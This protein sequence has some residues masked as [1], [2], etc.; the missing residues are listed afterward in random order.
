MIP[1]AFRF[2]SEARYPSG[3]VF[4]SDG[5]ELVEARIQV[6]PT[7]GF[8]AEF[9]NVFNQYRLPYVKSDKVVEAWHQSP[10]AFWQNQVNF[11]VWCASTGCGVSKEHLKNETMLSVYRF[12]LYFQTRRILTEMKCALPQDDSWNAFENSYDRRAYEQI[13]AEFSVSQNAGWKQHV[14]N[15]GLGDVYNYWTRNGY[16]KIGGPYNPDTM[17]FTTRTTNEILHVDYIAQEKDVS[18]TS[19]ILDTSDGFTRAGVERLNDSIRTYVWAILG[20]Q[21]QTRT[22]IVGTGTAFDAQKQFLA[23]VEDAISSPV[24]LPSAIGRYQD[25]LRYARSKVDFAY[26]IGL[27]MAPSNMELR[28]GRIQNYNNE[29][30]VAGPEQVLGVNRDANAEQAPPQEH[31]T[32]PEPRVSQTLAA[33]KD[34]SHDEEKTAIIV[35]GILLG[36][37][38]L[39]VRNIVW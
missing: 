24:D 20:A 38:L 34:D 36:F 23:N 32:L 6:S 5:I 10:M 15:D 11:A 25:V 1:K 26:G 7:S 12:H 17:S 21:A 35:G 3:G 8:T 14:G 16:H 33:E 27:Y 37:T 18:W 30:V 29:I 19:F 9:P 2:N 28:I 13:C 22:S 4:Q 39:F 31:A